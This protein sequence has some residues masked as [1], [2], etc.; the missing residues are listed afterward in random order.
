MKSA[1]IVSNAL[2]GTDGVDMPIG[3][4]VYN[5]PPPTIKRMANAC[6]F[7]ADLGDAQSISD[8]LRYVASA[9]DCARALSVFIAGDTSLEAELADAPFDDVVAA[10]MTALGL[11]DAKNFLTLLAS[12]KNVQ[13]LIAKPK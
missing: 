4:K 7:L 13:M 11:I 5:I 12:V 8:L 6:V 1:K 9:E 3:G 10:L 2:S